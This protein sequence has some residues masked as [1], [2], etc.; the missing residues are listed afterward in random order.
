MRKFLLG[1]ICFNVMGLSY[2]SVP[3][4][5]Q[6]VAPN[7]PNMVT[8]PNMQ[9]REIRSSGTPRS[10]T[11]LLPS[12]GTSTTQT[13]TPTQPSS[14]NKLGSGSGDDLDTTDEANPANDSDP[15]AEIDTDT[16]RY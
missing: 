11:S 12:G 3:D 15:E 6:P 1:I 5:A 4:N 10:D 7:P 14:P 9:D 13:P 2:A 16:N 8:P